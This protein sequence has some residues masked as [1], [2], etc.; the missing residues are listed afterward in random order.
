LALRS[1]ATSTGQGLGDRRS[2]RRFAGLWL[3]MLAIGL[4]ATGMVL[5]LQQT[6]AFTMRLMSEAEAQA[7]RVAIDA[8]KRFDE[9][10]AA[11]LETVESSV[12]SAAKPP[13][14]MIH[15]PG[16]IDAVFLWNGDRLTSL[17]GQPNIPDRLYQLVTARL[18]VRSFAGLGLPGEYRPEMLYDVL[19]SKPIILA[20][21]DAQDHHGQR[22][23]VVASVH[24]DRVRSELLEPL[25][26]A[27]SGLEIVPMGGERGFTHPVA[28]LGESV[29]S[30][31]LS[32]PLRYWGIRP[33]ERF[34]NEQQAAV[35]RQTLVYLGLTI[36]ALCTL[37]G[38]MWFL[39]RVTRREMALAE[40]KANFV[41][42]VSHEL[43]TP[44]ALISMFA[45]TLQSG[46]VQSEEKRNEYYEII[47]RESTR[48]TN[49]INNILDFARIEA[50]KKLYTLESIDA[51]QVVT[52]TYQAYAAQLDASGFEHHLTVEP[53]LPP[54]HA[55]RGAIAQA[56]LNLVNNAIKYSPHER[57]L[58]IEVTKD[59][60]RG[61]H[62]V[63][64]SVHDRG[65]G[66][67]PEDRAR[68]T[69]GFF[70]ASD[71]RVRTQGGTGLGLAL[72]KHIVEE[73]Y[74]TLDI[75][76]RLVRGSTF[77]I[78]LPAAE[79]DDAKNANRPDKFVPGPT[80]S[81]ASANTDFEV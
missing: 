28:P 37:L 72:V 76:S 38:A 50:G 16:W 74:G 18:T 29:W 17:P 62:G 30:Q 48:L 60:R 31:P 44:L 55:D 20:C 36:L 10:I 8:R 53:N 13:D 81:G 58:A 21:M 19:D 46:R 56:V 40:L 77:R 12:K 22:Y 15:L 5:A 23:T 54:V 33:T 65:I 52:D 66:I 25:L 51:G 11:A 69:E 24:P 49:L 68:L 27:G 73:H 57:Y 79:T 34:V 67:K 41:A 14:R 63:L 75:E 1:D 47:L 32:G 7:T 9:K 64:I 61:R 2:I 59:T 42:D 78:F 45:E 6:R 26:P 70:R 71:G 3:V 4:A 43:K 39:L 80:E 35:V